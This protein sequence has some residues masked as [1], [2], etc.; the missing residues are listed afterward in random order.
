MRHAFAG[1]ETCWSASTSSYELCKRTRALLSRALVTVVLPEHAEICGRLPT[2]L[3]GPADAV[4]TTIVITVVITVVITATII[5]Y[6]GHRSN[7]SIGPK[8][9]PRRPVSSKIGLPRVMNTSVHVLA[10]PAYLLLVRHVRGAVALKDLAHNLLDLT[11]CF[12]RDH[13][14]PAITRFP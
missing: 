2:Q 3:P 14:C 9:H 12:H 7:V 11:R 6:V 5:L 4:V 10:S 1:I 13:G 8:K